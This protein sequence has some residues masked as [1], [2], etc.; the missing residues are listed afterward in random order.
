[1]MKQCDYYCTQ[2]YYANGYLRSIKQEC[3]GTKE[4]DECSCGGDRTKCTFY[5]EIREKA[6]KE[7]EPKFGEWISVEDRLPERGMRCLVCRKNGVTEYR[8]IEI[9]YYSED[10]NITHWQPLPELPKGEQL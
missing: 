1:M 7:Q 10:K 2:K 5:P 8:W 9:I 3:W 6:L 4:R